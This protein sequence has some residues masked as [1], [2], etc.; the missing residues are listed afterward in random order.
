[1]AD[2]LTD[3]D[4]I[5]DYE[6]LR[7]AS[8]GQGEIFSRLWLPGAVMEAIPSAPTVT[9]PRAIIQIAHGMAEHSARYDEFARFLT[10]KGF[11]V[12]MNDHAG[13]GAHADK[14]G[15]LGY[16]ADERGPYHVTEDMH[17]LFDAV[18]KKDSTLSSI[19]KFLLGHSMGSFLSRKYISK[20]GGELAG[21]I[22]S[23]TAGRNP[24]LAAGKTLAALQVKVKGPKSEGKLLSK[25]GF[26]SYNKRIGSPVNCDAW[27]STVDDVCIRYKDD[28]Y[29]GFPFTALG[30]YDLFSVMGEIS[31]PGWAPSVPKSLPLYIVSGA[32]DPVGAYGKGVTEVYDRLKKTGHEDV[33]L[34]IYPG[35]RHEMLNESNR[36]EVYEDVLAWLNARL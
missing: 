26:G 21:C 12:C 5:S 36:E 28:P 20:Y 15:T 11:V 18:I 8:S 1:M 35:G 31:E 2:N 23:G 19:P 24:A 6:W 13:H 25:I 17:S 3:K 34:K 14:N 30:F 7:P 4:K 22:L 16:F 27:L 33:T 29:C 10:G 9:P 32:E